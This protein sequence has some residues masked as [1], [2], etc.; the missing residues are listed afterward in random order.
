MALDNQP[1]QARWKRRLRASEAR[2]A[3]E[4]SALQRGF[5]GQPR[6]LK[7]QAT[8]QMRRRKTTCWRMIAFVNVGRP[9]TGHKLI[10]GAPSAEFGM[11]EE[12][13]R[14]RDSALEA[15][16]HGVGCRLPNRECRSGGAGGPGG[17]GGGWRQPPRRRPW[18]RAGSARNAPNG[19]YNR[20]ILSFGFWD[21][22]P[23]RK[24]AEAELHR[25]LARRK[26]LKPAE[27]AILFQWCHMSF[28]PSPLVS[29]K[30]TAERLS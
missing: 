16:A 4:R 23:K 18:D 17:G 25:T 21:I 28:A 11:W 27:K 5:S 19:Q 24:R 12:G 8:L 15:I 22:P 14:P 7:Y 20:H 29:S 13:G 30:R 9:A 3:R 6:I 2:S 26:A 10:R 1:A